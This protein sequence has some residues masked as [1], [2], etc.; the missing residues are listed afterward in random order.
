MLYNL[1]ILVIKN[2][3]MTK[4]L[5]VSWSVQYSDDLLILTRL[6]LVDISRFTSFLDTETPISP[7]TEIGSRTFCPD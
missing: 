7:N 4:L 6:F 5:Y 2:K 3:T 1:L